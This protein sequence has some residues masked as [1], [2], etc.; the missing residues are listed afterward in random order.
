MFLRFKAKNA[1][2]FPF[3]W[4]DEAKTVMEYSAMLTRMSIEYER[5]FSR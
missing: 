3:E 1:K 2:P 4:V 5:R